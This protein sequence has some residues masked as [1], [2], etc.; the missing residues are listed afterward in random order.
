MDTPAKVT[1]L[2]FTMDPDENV[3]RLYITVHDMLFM[4]VF[5]RGSHLSNILGGFPFG[6]PVLLAEMLVQFSST[7]KLQ[8][9]EDPL[10]VVKMAI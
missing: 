6:K 2:D 4:Q 1:D 5:E 3:F 10:A 7:G 9:Q 8:D